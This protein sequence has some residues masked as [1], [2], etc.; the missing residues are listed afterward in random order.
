MFDC[1]AFG[2]GAHGDVGGANIRQVAEPAV[3]FDIAARPGLLDV[4]VMY[5]LMPGVCAK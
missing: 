3:S 4:S 2:G 5:F 1:V